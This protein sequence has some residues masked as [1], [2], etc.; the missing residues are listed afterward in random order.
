MSG[1]KTFNVAGGINTS[2]P[3]LFEHITSAVQAYQ[4][5]KRQEKEAAM[6]REQAIQQRIAE[7]R[8]KTASRSQKIVVQTPP[9]IK[10]ASDIQQLDARMQQ[11]L[12]EDAQKQVENLKM[13]LPQIKLA[14][15]HLVEQ[16]F[17]DAE[18]VEN[19]IAQ[20]E[21]SLQNRNLTAA[22]TYLQVLDDARIQATQQLKTEST[23]QLEFLQ[24][25]LNDLHT[26]LPVSITQQLQTQIIDL[27]NNWTSISDFDIE[28]LHKEISTCELQIE[29]IQTA[30]E[31]LIASWQQVGY[32]AQ[33]SAIDNGDVIVEIETHEGANT[34]KRIFRRLVKC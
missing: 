32:V 15:K 24:T 10:S 27:C 26:R 33:I 22:Q 2:Q 21:I 29:Q 1:R 17:L 7:I 34:Q 16:H 4:E 20:A 6:R 25:R 11:A 3:G 12:S 28:H 19:A 14:Y 13:Q 18:S 9:E 8:A 5:R 23:Q 31:N 30:A